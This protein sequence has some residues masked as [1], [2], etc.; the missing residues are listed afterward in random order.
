MEP[1]A[2]PPDLKI[3]T[4]WSEPGGRARVGRS[5]VLSL[6]THAA[7]IAFLIFVPETLWQPSR[8]KETDAAVTPLFLPRMTL[9]QKEPNPAK[10][11]REFRSPDLTPRVHAPSGPSTEPQAAKPPKPVP[12]PPPPPK[13]APPTSLPEPPKVEIASSEPPK[14]TLPV[15]SPQ[16]PQPK[17]QPEFENVAP[18]TPVPPEQRVVDL[19]GSLANAGRGALAGRGANAQGTAPI[20]SSGAELPRLLSDAQGVDWRPYLAEVLDSVRRYW[21]SIL[22]P[23]VT[24]GGLRGYVSVQFVIN[25]DGTVGKVVFAQRTGSPTLDRTAI[26]AISGG[27]PFGPFP[28]QYRGSEIRVE[29]NFAYNAP[30]Q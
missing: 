3:L 23:S 9:T 30:R 17:S 7:A 1:V 21:K 27:G 2:L 16:V 25:R 18:F 13:V 12:A 19:S 4:D 15:Q 22:P 11:I 6:L 8:P 14:L 20:A 29:M 5:A 26:E 28:G 24:K 10:Q